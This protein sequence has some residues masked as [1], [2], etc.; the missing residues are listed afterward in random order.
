MNPPPPDTTPALDENTARWFAE[1]VEPHEFRLRA[2]LATR[3]PHLRDLDDVVQETYVRLFRARRA[4]GV[5][6]VQAFL[7]SAARNAA[8]DVFRRQRNCVFDSMEDAAELRLLE[9]TP[10]V[11]EIVSA[12]QELE[13]LAEAIRQLPHRCRQVFTLRKIYGLSQRE[14][15][16]Q[17]GISE[18]TVEVQM[19]KGARRC[20]EFLRSRGITR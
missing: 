16:A 6:S 1:E 12:S 5:R 20:A 9:D 15:A 10:D 4:G 7:F 11:A 18:H 3:F 17:L 8:C 14:V 13:V 19:G 2:W